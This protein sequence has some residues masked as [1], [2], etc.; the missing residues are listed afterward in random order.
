MQRA[1]Q[2]WRRFAH[3]AAEIQSNVLLFLM[4]FL[5]VVPLSALLRIGRA[6]ESTGWRSLPGQK[7]RLDEARSQF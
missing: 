7:P 3:R 2:R 1:W 4:F 6:H 5:F